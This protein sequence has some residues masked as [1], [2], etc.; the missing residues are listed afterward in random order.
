MLEIWWPL[1]FFDLQT[2]LIIHLV[3]ELEI[4]GFVGSMW[5]YPIKQYLHV[6]KKYVRN[7]AKPKGCIALGYMY[8]ETLSFTIEYLMLYAHTTRRIWDVNEE[9]VDVG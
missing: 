5:C 7:K 3:D 8:D 9:E 2:H 1:G 4:C 6:L